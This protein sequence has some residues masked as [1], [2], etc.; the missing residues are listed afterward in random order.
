MAIY[1]LSARFLIIALPVY[2]RLGDLM[3]AF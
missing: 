3:E 2:Y 1:P